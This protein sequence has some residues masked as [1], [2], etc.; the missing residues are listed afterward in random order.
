MSEP[1]FSARL[2]AATAPDHAAAEQTGFLAELTRGRLSVAAHTALT[3]QHYLIY[4]MLEQ[5]AERMR[6]D[7][8]A[9][10]FADRRLTRL[11]ALTADLAQLA[12][13]DWRDLLVPNEATSRYVARLRET[14]FVSPIGFVAHHY[15]RYLGDLSGGQYV[16]RAL[17]KAY[18]LPLGGPGLLFYRFD[19][20]PDLG[21]TKES[22]R[23]ELDA[24]GWND[25]EQA[26]F[27][28]EVKIAYRLNVEVLEALGHDT[29]HLRNP[30]DA[31]VIAQVRKHMNDDHA[32]DCL[33]IVQALGGRRDA[34]GAVMSGMDGDGIDFVATVGSQ[35][36][37]VRVPWSYQ[38]T[39]RAQVRVEVTR[40]YHEAAAL[41]SAG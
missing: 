17:S 3:A 33:I 15:N 14:A 16:A 11:P 7:P 12:G 40:M 18:G 6:A 2:R 20:L 4:D 41:L 24:A 5:A 8:I 29:A 1:L 39:E 27:I 31:E 28:D 35:Q 25:D 19:E 32:A 13:P 37:E 9:A 10:R 21:A 22:Y 34:G 30:F 23:A 36:V 38:L 26:E